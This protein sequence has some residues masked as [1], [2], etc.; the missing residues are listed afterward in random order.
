MVVIA[1]VRAT[2]RAMDP[3]AVIDG[4]TT[5]DAVLSRAIAPWRMS[6]WLF[7]LFST[8]AFGLATVGLFSVVSLEVTSRQH[9]FAIRMALGADRRDIM[10]LVLSMTV[11]LVGVGVPLG[12]LIA[13]MGTRALRS[14]LFGVELLDGV[15]YLSVIGLV[16]GVVAAAS[17]L[18]A[19]RAAGIEPLTL[20]RR[21]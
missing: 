10:H 13:V 15:T 2:V 16:I 8:L 14:L 19:R 12:L 3:R 5:M 20:L 11:R 7:T 4:V 21:E 18:P 1:A 9:D 6:A 17:Y